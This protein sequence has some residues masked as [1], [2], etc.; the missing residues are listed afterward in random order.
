MI[1]E[2]IMVR[3]KV[4]KQRKNTRKKKKEKKSQYWLEI[5]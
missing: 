4:D 1:Y 5:T 2:R 3:L